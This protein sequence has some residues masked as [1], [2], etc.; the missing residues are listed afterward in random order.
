MFL[1]LVLEDSVG[2]FVFLVVPVLVIL[3]QVDN[4]LIRFCIKVLFLCSTAPNFSPK[5]MCLTDYNI[6]TC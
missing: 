3:L 4:W 6:F 2:W 1:A 5:I